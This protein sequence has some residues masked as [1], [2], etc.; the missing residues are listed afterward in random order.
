[1]TPEF[2][3]R[4]AATAPRA[5]ARA[6][7]RGY[8]TPDAPAPDPVVVSAAKS[9]ELLETFVAAAARRDAEI[10]ERLRTTSA[11]L[12]EET[13]HGLAEVARILALPVRPV[14]DRNGKLIEARR[15]T[16]TE[17]D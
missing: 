8:V 12:R 2:E 11:E 13:Q 7:L 5:G 10:E 3:R 6:S 9:H 16:N 1:M 14:Y 15:I 4:I 17:G